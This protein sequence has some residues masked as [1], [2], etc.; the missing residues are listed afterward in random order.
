MTDLCRLKSQ[1]DREGVEDGNF[2]FF[3]SMI[4]SDAGNYMPGKLLEA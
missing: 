3:L 2:F 1:F 4:D